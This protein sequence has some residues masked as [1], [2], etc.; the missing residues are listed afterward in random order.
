MRGMLTLTDALAS[1]CLMSIMLLPLFIQ[2][3]ASNDYLIATQVS[4]YQKIADQILMVSAIKGYIREIVDATEMEG[5]TG[6]LLG[7]IAQLCP[8]SLVCRLCLYA[9]DG[10]L[11]SSTGSLHDTIYGEACY[12]ATT[13]KRGVIRLVCQVSV[14]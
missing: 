3:F 4:Y 5:N 10:F 14:R 12:Y 6:E 2:N 11:L 7:K 9:E 1:I 8:P 13:S